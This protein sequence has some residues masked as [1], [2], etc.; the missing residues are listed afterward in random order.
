MAVGASVPLEVLLDRP[1]LGQLAWQSA[2]GRDLPVLVVLT[3]M[4]A[5]A[6]LVANLAGDLGSQ[7]WAARLSGRRQGAR[8]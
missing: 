5:S 2:T 1:G 3:W 6:T 7:W 8:A 4:V